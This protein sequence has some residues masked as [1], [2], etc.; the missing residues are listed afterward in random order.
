VFGFLIENDDTSPEGDNGSLTC[1]LQ[2]SEVDPAAALPFAEKLAEV[3][4]SRG[5]NL[6]FVRQPSNQS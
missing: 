2:G 5:R 4:Q 1:W 6:D 3:D